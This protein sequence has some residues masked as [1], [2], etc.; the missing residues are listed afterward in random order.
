MPATDAQ[1]FLIGHAS[2]FV[3]TDV[4]AWVWE[5]DD[6]IFG[7]RSAWQIDGEGTAVT[8]SVELMAGQLQLH[9]GERDLHSDDQS[10]QTVFEALVSFDDRTVTMNGDAL[11]FDDASIE[12]VIDRF[13]EVA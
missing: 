5:D 9:V 12:L 4:Q 6:A 8:A 3:A 7:K 2:R 13:N 1:S 11:P 10:L